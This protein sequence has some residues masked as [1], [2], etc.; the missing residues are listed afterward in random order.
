LCSDIQV[1]VDFGADSS[2]FCAADAVTARFTGR[3]VWLSGLRQLGLGALAVV[4]TYFVGH[5][6]GAQVN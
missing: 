5:L 3:N 2:H 6:I 4:V 1:G